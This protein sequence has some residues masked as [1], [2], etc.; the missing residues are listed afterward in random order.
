[1]KN[2]YLLFVSLLSCSSVIMLYLGSRPETTAVYGKIRNLRD[3]VPCCK[4]LTKEC[5]ACAAGMLVHKFCEQHPGRYRCPETTTVPVA[6]VPTTTV[7]LAPADANIC[8]Q[9]DT[10]LCKACHQGISVEEYV[11]RT[12]RTK[13]TLL[14]VNDKKHA[15]KYK[16][17]TITLERY[18]KKNGYSLLNKSPE[19]EP[20]CNHVKHFFFKK[21]CTV[22]YHIMDN[23]V[24]NDRWY[25]V[26]DGDNAVRNPNTNIR[27]ETF[28]K[29][30]KDLL[31]YYRFH[32]NEIAAGNYAIKNTK[33]AMDYLKGYYNLYNTYRGFNSDNGALHYYLLPT[34]YKD[35]CNNFLVQNLEIYFK[36]VGCVHKHLQMAGF[37]LRD[38]IFV[39]QHGTGWSYDGWVIDYKWSKDTLM[40]HAMK[41]PPMKGRTYDN[42]YTSEKVLK[43]LLIDTLK[44]RPKKL[45]NTGWQYTK[46]GWTPAPAPAP[47]P[48]APKIMIGIPVYN[49]QGY[50]RFSSR[51][52]IQYNEV[53]PKDIFVFDDA[54]TEYDENKLREWYGKDIHYFRSSKRL[55][56][57]GNTRRLFHYFAKSDYDILLTLDSDL[58]LDLK[59]KQFVY[60]HIG[61]SGVLSLYHSGIDYHKTFN[62]NGNLCEKKSMGNAGAVMTKSVVVNMLKNHKSSQ[63]DWGWVA[64]FKSRG[65][66]MYVP[67]NSLVLHYGKRGQNNK[68]WT[69]ELARGFDRNALPSWIKLR[70]FFYFDQCKK[71][72]ILYPTKTIIIVLSDREAFKERQVIRE[73]W[74]KN[75]SNVYFVVGKPCDIPPKNRKPWVCEAKL[76]TLGDETYAQEQSRISK[77][78]Q[79]EKDIVHVDMIDVYRN[80]AEKL[81]L[82][83]KWVYKTH[84]EAYVVKVDLDTF[85]RVAEVENFVN[86]RQIKYECIVGGISQGDVLRNGKWAENKYKKDKYPPFP[87]GSGHIVSPDLLKYIV[88]HEMVT[89]QGEDTSLGIFFDESDIDVTFTVT[90]SI[91]THSGDCFNKKA[92]IIGHNIDVSKM[93]KCYGS[94]ASVDS[95]DSV[96][97]ATIS[98][99]TIRFKAPL[100]KSSDIVVGIL[101]Y[102]KEKRDILRNYM[103]NWGTSNYFVIGKK[104]G[105][106]DE[107]EFEEYGDIILIDEEE[108]YF[109][110]DSILPFKTQLFF[111]VVQQSG[112]DFKYALKIDEDSKVDMDMLKEELDRLKP[113]YWGHLWR[114]GGVNRDPRAR[115]SVSK[116]LY[117]PNIFPPYC[118]GAGYVLS[119]TAVKCI[120]SKLAFHKY[121]PREDVATGLLAKACN[122]KATGTSKIKPGKGH[123]DGKWIISHYYKFT[124]PA[125]KHF[126]DVVIVSGYVNC[127][128]KKTIDGLRR[129][130]VNIGKI[131]VITMPYLVKQCEDDLDVYCHDEHTVLK[132][133]DIKFRNKNGWTAH[134]SRTSWYYQQF[135]KLFAYQSI[136]LTKQ[137]MIWDADN[138]L[139]KRYNPMEGQKTRFITGG[140][141][142]EFYPI[143]TTALT[144]KVPNRN[145]IVV[146][147]MMIQ[148][149]I[150]DSLMM[151]MCGKVKKESCV[152][153]IVDQIPKRADSKLGFSEYNLYYTWFHSKMPT[154]VYIDPS[155]KFKR[156]DSR[157][158]KTG[159][160]KDCEFNQNQY[161]KNVYMTVLETKRDDPKSLAWSSGVYPVS[162]KE[163]KWVTFYKNN[164]KLCVHMGK[165]TVSN[166]IEK[167]GKW[168]DCDIL[169]TLWKSEKGNG[170]YVEIGANIGACMMEMISNTDAK[171]TVFE[172]NPSNLF[173][174]TS[175][176]EGLPIDVR[177]RITVYPFALG[178]NIGSSVLYSSTVNKGNSVVGKKVSGG[179]KE[180]F[181]EYHIKVRRYDGVI[182]HKKVKLMKMDAQGYECS[183]VIGMGSY[184]PNVIKT[185]IANKWLSAHDNCS[186]KRLF[187]LLHANHMIVY[188]E[189]NKILPHPKPTSGSEHYDIIARFDLSIRSL[190]TIKT[191]EIKKL[192]DYK[193]WRNSIFQTRTSVPECK[194]PKILQDTSTSKMICMDNIVP[195][196]CIVYSFGINYQ[197]DFDDYMHNYGCTVYSFDPGMDYKSKRAERHFF[198]KI[199]LGAKTGIH[200][201]S[202]TL[203]SGRK[204]YFVETVDSIM[205]RLGHSKVDLL[206]MDTEGAEFDVLPHLPYNKIGQL[207]LEIHMWSHSFNDWNNKIRDIPLQHLQTYQNTDRINKK[208]MQEISPGVTRVY[209]MTFLG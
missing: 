129:N 53:D 108:R 110:D 199:G 96:D 116:S 186:D 59:W 57:D 80:L 144:G 4:A 152:N 164:Y 124:K 46:N 10:P 185:E 123:K 167:T 146:H 49:R 20:R 90:K 155:I 184:I 132:R 92:M 158:K 118:S 176:K 35:S 104:N 114:R 141:K 121:M 52:L 16:E 190:E 171:I 188:S 180:V 136:S 45:P 127:V 161:G 154:N 65:I 81:K 160:G 41:R 42:K 206:R 202:S 115:E 203:Y 2:N 25:F 13:I 62:C 111:H 5:M 47:A 76:Q 72:N 120:A 195:G 209:E 40:H 194:R 66:K 182:P 63:F 109:G 168:R 163:C 181:D 26:L 117:R 113:N 126:Y 91:I 58:I 137:F 87:Y 27:L 143:T 68:C 128:L 44:T 97:S 112:I 8:C 88:T 192:V 82:A 197:W 105:F 156:T 175:T 22:Y 74:A 95:V 28:I 94:A 24:T 30:D 78:L 19:D 31:Y 204:N 3:R 1:M 173:C 157:Y 79:A 6:P 139:L 183:I 106:Y 169:S 64:Y 133:S 14:I 33:W 69:N 149:E 36:F 159:T 142:N 172:P 100:M 98:G 198:E 162:G 193:K 61:K 189:D 102:K 39:Y 187:E 9:L 138:I 7:A 140:W 15:K 103:Q 29:N 34:Q 12:V 107:T 208:T 73:T 18:A 70:L 51:V 50:V 179:S 145:D 201:G 60:D 56:A 93:K 54:S 166:E 43:Q 71:S 23:G 83:Y 55:K 125:K 122:I 48:A 11:K 32:N 150:L 17:N 131:H 67:K 170:E 21:H 174:L 101:S 200:N 165:D 37:P 85:V 38:H 148:T 151:H 99:K 134:K 130:L 89:Y 77:Q 119:K 153:M 191:S 177:S 135:L 207:S 147:Q 86:D 205:K 75:H 178:E 196:S 84:G